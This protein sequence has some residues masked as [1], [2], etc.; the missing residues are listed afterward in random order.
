[1]ADN[2]DNSQMDID[3]LLERLLTVRKSESQGTSVSLTEQEIDFLCGR[4]K[5]IFLSQPM[6]LELKAPIKIFG[7]L[8]GYYDSLLH[9]LEQGGWPPESNYLFLGNYVDR[10]KQSIEVICLL[11]AYK[12]KYPN[13]IFLLRGNHECSSINRIYGFYDQCKRQ[14]NVK[15]WK[16]F[17]HCFNCL[18][19]AAIIGEKIFCCQGGLSPDFQSFDQIRQIQRPTDVPD[20]G[21]LHALL[22]SDP[23]KDIKRWN[24]NDASVSYCF[25]VEIVYEFLNQHNLDLICRSHQI[26]ENGYEFFA[27]HHLVTIFSAPDYC[28]EYDNDGAIM[29]VNENLTYSFM[30]LHSKVRRSNHIL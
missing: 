13:N 14:Y 29:S 11:L 6:L 12:I 20:H 2:N 4:S 28:E 16:T 17:N 30:V 19:A 5:E 23:D 1:M 8:H 27:D 21:V 18:P 9:F 24:E 25:G 22:W 26:V 15:L 7:N 3:N 10:G